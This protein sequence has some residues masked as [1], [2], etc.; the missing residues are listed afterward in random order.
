[1]ESPFLTPANDYT[2]NK[3]INLKYEEKKYILVIKSNSTIISFSLYLEN[4]SLDKYENIYSLKDL[5]NIN[6]SFSIFNSIED[7]RKQIEEILLINKYSIILDTDSQI[8]LIL[9]ANIFTQIIDINFILKKKTIN[10][11]EF[12]MKINKQLENLNKEVNRLKNE[13][14]GFKKKIEEIQNENKDLKIV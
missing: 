10:Q 8:S 11:T 1:M 4:E 13:N 14:D 3:E 6:K 7:V 5:T 9:K 2:Y 12:N